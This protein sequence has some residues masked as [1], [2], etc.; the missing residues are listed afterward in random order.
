MSVGPTFVMD[1]TRYL[2]SIN[3][4]TLEKEQAD[5]LGKVFKAHVEP[6]SNLDLTKYPTPPKQEPAISDSSAER[7]LKR[8]GNK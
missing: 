8:W 6:I 3:P 4:E 2:K 5:N 1:L 7:T